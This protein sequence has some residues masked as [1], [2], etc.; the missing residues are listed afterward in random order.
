MEMMLKNNNVHENIYRNEF[1]DAVKE[2]EQ[3]LK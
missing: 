3:W 1:P 2:I